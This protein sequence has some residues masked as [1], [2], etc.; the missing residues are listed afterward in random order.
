MTKP[1]TKS[2][3]IIVGENSII[4]FI[5]GFA[6]IVKTEKLQRYVKTGNINCNI[7]TK[8]KEI[9]TLKQNMYGIGIKAITYVCYH[10][11]KKNFTMKREEIDCT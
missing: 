11:K 8:W 6:K 1:E 2:I 10:V 7:V 3:I 4:L 9:F 5:T